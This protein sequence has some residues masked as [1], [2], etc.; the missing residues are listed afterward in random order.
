MKPW[1]FSRKW[2]DQVKA[3]QSGAGD[4]Q[5]RRRVAKAT[6]TKYRACAQK[7]R[8]HWTLQAERRDLA[9]KSMR[10]ICVLLSKVARAQLGP[11]RKRSDDDYLL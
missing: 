11:E 9:N 3:P 8:A 7:L 10:N 1:R 6:C 5:K 4:M 2:R